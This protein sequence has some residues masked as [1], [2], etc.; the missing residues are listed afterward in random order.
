M[1][2]E[3]GCWACRGEK[4]HGQIGVLATLLDEFLTNNR[5][6]LDKC[7]LINRPS[8]LS[9]IFRCFYIMKPVGG[10]DTDV[11]MSEEMIKCFKGPML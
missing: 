11:D 2:Q 5:F 6:N 10:T 9:Y 3:K 4:K 1:F 8:I 7:V